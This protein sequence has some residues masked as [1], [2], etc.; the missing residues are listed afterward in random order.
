[1]QPPFPLSA[2]PYCTENTF[3]SGPVWRDRNG[4]HWAQAAGDDGGPASIAM[5]YYYVSQPGFYW[6]AKQSP[7]RG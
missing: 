7:A 5:Q 4:S 1:M 6:P 2:V 3:V